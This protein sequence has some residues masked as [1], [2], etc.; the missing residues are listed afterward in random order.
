LKLPNKLSQFGHNVRNSRLVNKPIA[1]V[2][3]NTITGKMTEMSR[4][5]NR[6]VV[7][8]CEL[9]LVVAKQNF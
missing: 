5:K 2:R 8:H 4:E 6:F 9:L 1:T 7:C 3:F